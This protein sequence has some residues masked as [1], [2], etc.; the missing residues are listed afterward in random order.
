MEPVP[1]A[2]LGAALSK[3]PPRRPVIACSVCQ[4]R[5]NSESQA[6]AHYQGNRHA[7]RLKG[8]EAARARRGG[9]PAEPPPATETPDRP[10][11]EQPPA[12]AAPGAPGPPSPPPAVT[13]EAPG[14]GRG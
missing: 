7:R 2:V 4:I 5:F 13:A 9:D 6:A 1:K 11:G 14:G 3:P 12:P 10:A 8:L